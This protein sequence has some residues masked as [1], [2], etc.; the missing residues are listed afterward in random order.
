M[1]VQPEATS[2][3]PP[4]ISAARTAG[5][6]LF[7]LTALN[8]F[9][10]IDRYILPGVQPLVQKE[11]H[12]N[13]AQIGFLT[14]AFFFTYMLVAPLTGWLGDRFPRKPL[15]IIGA[16]L[17]SAAT[18]YTYWVHSYE[19]LLVRHAVVGIGEATF[20]IF[21]PA[22]LSDFYP[23]RD[24]N[25]IL[26]IFYVTIPVGGALGYITGGVLGQ[27]YGWRMPFFIAAL[28]G[29]LIA[30]GFWLFVREPKRGSADVLAP[31]L[32]RATLRGLSGNAAFWCATLG[33][34]MW[35][36]AVGGISTFLPTFFVRFA[37]MSVAKAGTVTGALTVVDGLLGTV[38]GG[39]LGQIWLRKNHRALYLISA[40]GSILAIP[41]AA[42]VFFGPSTFFLPAAFVAEF[43][44]FLGTGP[45]NAAIVNSVAAPIRATAIS[46]NLFVIHV[47][48]DAFSPTIIGKISDATNLRIGLGITLITLTLS[49]MILFTGARY[50][51]ILNRTPE[52]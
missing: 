22:L 8:L 23:E 51:P 28:P 50:A 35:T 17:W 27:H 38:V 36:F 47:L 13:D 1:Q 29:V 2:G 40:W 41:A 7:L 4:R 32:D 9:N 42:L 30:L 24:R 34:A 26:S 48:G 20:S 5:T 12:V 6:A 25:R 46:V 14:T 49:G 44:L 18:L 43:F 15:I 39:W 33:L 45:L 19:T 52:P 3:N 10:F 21:A 16:L 11:F 31:T 37:H